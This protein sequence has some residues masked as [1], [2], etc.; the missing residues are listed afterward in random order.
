MSIKKV[1]K[2]EHISEETAYMIE[3]YPW[4]FKLRT[5][6]KIWIEDKKG[7]GQRIVRQTLNPKTQKWCNPKKST[8]YD[9]YVIFIDEENH[10][11]TDCLTL[12]HRDPFEVQSFLDKY[13][14]GLTQPYINYA[15][16][17]IEASKINEEK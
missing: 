16:G 8:Y 12:L 7:L 1:L 4:G 15:E 3:D 10:I 2:P 13:K 17:Y 9:F 14:E 11:K 5:K 6:M